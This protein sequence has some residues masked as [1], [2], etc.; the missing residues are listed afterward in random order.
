MAP[1]RTMTDGGEPGAIIDREPLPSAPLPP[2]TMSMP[3]LEPRLWTAT[4]ILTL[5]D[6]PSHRYEC[7][8]GVLLV[9]PTPRVAHQGAVTALAVMI[10]ALLRPRGVGTVFVAPSEWVLD[11]RTLV[12]P[13]VYVVPL[14]NGHRPRSE[15]ERG[16]PLLFIEVLSAST[17]R[18]DR[19]VKRGRYQR[20]NIEYWIVDLDSRLV[21][22]WLPD[23]ERPTIHAEELT[24]QPVGATAPFVIELEPFFTEV[25]GPA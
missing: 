23:D 6:D 14:A 7:V 20:A 9:S 18:Y 17:A 10:E 4:E 8:D 13:D 15:E 24:W 11:A 12:Q 2:Q 22:R 5:P 25:L 1:V 3:A 21:E 19:V 16:H